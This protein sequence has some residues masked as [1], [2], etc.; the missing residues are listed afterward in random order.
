MRAV[1][2]GPL[3][4][5]GIKQGDVILTLNHVPVRDAAH[6]AEQAKALPKGKH[7]PLYIVRDAE[8][9]FLPLKIDP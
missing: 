7:V 9:S 5:A 1:G 4:A 3:Q 2:S 8:P 6:F